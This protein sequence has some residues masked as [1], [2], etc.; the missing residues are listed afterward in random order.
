MRNI[1]HRT[2]GSGSGGDTSERRSYLRRVAAARD[3][4][5]TW[6]FT[7]KTYDRLGQERLRDVIPLCRETSR[8]SPLAPRMSE[9][10]GLGGLWSTQTELFTKSLRIENE[11]SVGVG[12]CGGIRMSKKG[13]EMG[14]E[15]VSGG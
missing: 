2:S 13:H 14:V 11:G 5:G 10:R 9:L 12:H 1:W 8:T 7:T 6:S 3:R 4:T 15:M